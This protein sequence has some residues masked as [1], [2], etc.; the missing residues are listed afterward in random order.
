M[1]FASIMMVAAAMAA[2]ESPTDTETADQY[3]WAASYNAA[4]K[5]GGV[6]GAWRSASTLEITADRRVLLGNNY[7]INPQVGESTI[8]WSMA[9][10]NGTNAS[11]QLLVESS[12]TY[13]WGDVGVA[14]KLYQGWIQYPG[15]G[16]LD[17][18]G[19]AR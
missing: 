17:Y 15:E 19:L 11:I 2:C 9:D 8:S 18:R 7:I 4:T 1:R 16:K 10:G 6:N 13:F 3:R 12:S 14:G 5:W